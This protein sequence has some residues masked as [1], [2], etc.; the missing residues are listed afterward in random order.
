[1]YAMCCTVTCSSVLTS[2]VSTLTH[3]LLGTWLHPMPTCVRMY[4]IQC[5]HMQSILQ[6]LTL[7]HNTMKCL[8]YNENPS[9]T[10]AFSHPPFS[11]SLLP[12]PPS[13]LLLFSSP[14]SSLSSPS[15]LYII[16]T[17][18]HT[19][20]HLLHFCPS[21]FLLYPASSYPFF[22]PPPHPTLHFV[23]SSLMHPSTST[24]LLQGFDERESLRYICFHTVNRVLRE[25]LV[26]AFSSLT[27]QW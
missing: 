15:R 2:Q 3:R 27:W 9:L 23:S 12:F 1:M 18:P 13:L 26:S 17:P 5:V 21:L 11:L 10:V 6:S 25:R 22:P 14:P 20:I 24:L 8:Q 7:T 4:C 19:C 16:H